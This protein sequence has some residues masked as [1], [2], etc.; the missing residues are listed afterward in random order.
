MSRDSLT[1]TLFS[2]HHTE[3]T[4]LTAKK[5]QSSN[6]FD[7]CLAPHS[8]GYFCNRQRQTYAAAQHHS[9]S[10]CARAVMLLWCL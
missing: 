4:G 10:A 8:G 3:V 7:S 5:A 9:M 1:C 2:A 6:P